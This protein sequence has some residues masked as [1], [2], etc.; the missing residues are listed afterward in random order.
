LA[1]ELGRVPLPGAE[2]VSHGLRLRAEGGPDHRGRVR[3]GTVL[4][5]LDGRQGYGA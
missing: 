5:S 1:L 4:V 2:V 3:I